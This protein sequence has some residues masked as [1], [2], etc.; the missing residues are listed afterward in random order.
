MGG[1]ANGF[2][3]VSGLDGRVGVLTVDAKSGQF[4]QAGQSLNISGGQTLSSVS[5]ATNATAAHSFHSNWLYLGLG[6][7]AAAAL[8]AGLGRGGGKQ[9]SRPSG[10]CGGGVWELFGGDMSSIYPPCIAATG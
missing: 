4:L 1:A 9:S 6:G 10:P 3:L 2:C 8:A 7:A 5:G